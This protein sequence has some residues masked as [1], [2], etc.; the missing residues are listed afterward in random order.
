MLRIILLAVVLPMVLG[1][2]LSR[3]DHLGLRWL[4]Y[5]LLIV[6]PGISLTLLLDL[7]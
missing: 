5:T 4:G 6:P 7:I 3:L 2:L 1:F